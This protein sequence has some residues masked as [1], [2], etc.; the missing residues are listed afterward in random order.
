MHQLISGAPTVIGTV[1][2]QLICSHPFFLRLVSSQVMIASVAMSGGV[3]LTMRN[4]SS[5]RFI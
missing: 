3:S 2:R 1:G 4:G 5:A